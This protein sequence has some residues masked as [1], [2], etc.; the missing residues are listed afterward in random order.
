MFGEYLDAVKE[1]A[2]GQDRLQWNRQALAKQDIQLE[3]INTE[4]RDRIHCACHDL[5]EELDAEA[6]AS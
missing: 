6:A 2:I 5:I 3:A 1:L 4:Y